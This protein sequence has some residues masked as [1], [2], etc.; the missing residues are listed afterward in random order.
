MP[1]I[2]RDGYTPLVPKT[3]QVFTTAGTYTW[4]KPAGCIRVRVSLVG[5]GGGGAGYCEGGGAGGY[6]ESFIDVS[7]IESVDI[8]VGSGGNKVGYYGVASPGGVSSFGWFLSASGGFGANAHNSHEG[9]R[10]GYGNG[11]QLNLYGG[12]GSGHGNGMGSWGPNTGG[13]SYFGGSHARKHS[14]SSVYD[15]DRHCGWGAGG[16]GGRTDGT[17]EGSHGAH[18]AVVVYEYYTP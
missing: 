15:D 7:D 16:T 17:G 6:S 10:G 12:K 1:I 14:S 5:G 4:I 9:G 2:D 3:V 13:D 11:G 8:A 18:G